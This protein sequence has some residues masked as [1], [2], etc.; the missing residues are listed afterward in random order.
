MNRASCFAGKHFPAVQTPRTSLVMIS[1]QAAP[2]LRLDPLVALLTYA[3]GG[4]FIETN[5]ELN[6]NSVGSVPRVNGSDDHGAW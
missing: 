6:F 2:S 1:T 4:T 5:S 3:A